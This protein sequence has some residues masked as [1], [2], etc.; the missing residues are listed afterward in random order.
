MS[1]RKLQRFAEI[2]TFPNVFEPT[3]E[4]I[5]SGNYP[6]KGNWRKGFFRNEFPVILELGCGKGEYTIGLAENNPEKNFIGVDIKGARMWRGAKTSVE[7]KLPNVAFLRTRIEFI[8]SFFSEGEVDEIWITF[9]DPQPQKPRERKRLTAF[10]FLSIYKKILTEKGVVHLKTDNA[11]LFEY[12]L[13]VLH[14]NKFPILEST[15][16]LY[17]SGESIKHPDA[18]FIQTH[19]ER[20]FLKQGSKICYIKFKPG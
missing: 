6:L 8:D 16:D 5:R 1:K 15:H 18:A 13:G 4:E 2:K 19:Y 11:G 12:T 10:R 3:L 20:I 7:K 17:N 14:E 9:P